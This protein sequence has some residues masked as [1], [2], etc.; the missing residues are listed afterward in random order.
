[1]GQ[2]CVADLGHSTGP[3]MAVHTQVTIFHVGHKPQAALGTILQIISQFLE[4]ELPEPHHIASFELQV[5]TSG[6]L[7]IGILS[8]ER[9]FQPE[10]IPE[11]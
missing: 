7:L 9:E 3:S 10:A 4:L 8:K 1:M 2:L 11:V 5:P 6:V